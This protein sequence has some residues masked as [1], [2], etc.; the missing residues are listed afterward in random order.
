MRA[1]DKQ[2]LGKRAAW[3]TPILRQV[4]AGELPEEALG[5]LWD[6][7]TAKRAAAGLD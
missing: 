3:Q 2:T 1:T 7:L 4:G 6:A 5:R